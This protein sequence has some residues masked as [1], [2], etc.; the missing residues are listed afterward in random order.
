MSKKSFFGGISPAFSLS[1]KRINGVVADELLLRQVS[2]RDS[3]W[4]EHRANSDVVAGFYRGTDEFH[5][6]AESIDACSRLLDFRLVINEFGYS[7]KLDSAHFC[8]KRHCV[9]CQWRRALMW[10]AKAYECLPLVVNTYPDYRWLFLTLTVRNCQILDLRETIQF[11]HRSW[12]RL[13]ERK[14]FSGVGFIRSTEVTKGKNNSAHPHFHCLLL[15]KPSYFSG[16]CFMKHKD[17]V[18]L[19]RSCLRVDY[20]PVVDIRAISEDLSPTLVVPEILKYCVK[21][22]DLVSDREW[23][24]EL[25]RQMRYVRTVAT[26]G[27]LKDYLKQ[28]EEEP[29]DLIGND[30]DNSSGEPD[31]GHLL[32]EWKSLRKR[33]VYKR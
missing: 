6:Y 21:E 24:L 19:W 4:D 11:M 26:G 10:K 17:W 15:V 16:K 32:F 7:F 29:E 30:N 23:F 1:H 31:E 22:A 28:L 8:R 14:K 27:L 13:I 5:S 9:V 3:S 20:N 12:K 33:Y 18:N 2:E 25:T